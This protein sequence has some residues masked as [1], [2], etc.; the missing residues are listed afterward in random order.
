MAHYTCMKD[1]YKSGWFE[2]DSQGGH[3]G[4]VCVK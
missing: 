2:G 4:I 3:W 1:G